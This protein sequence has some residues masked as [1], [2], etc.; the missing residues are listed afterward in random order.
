MF[1]HLCNH[2]IVSTQAGSRLVMQVSTA[3]G[4]SG[5]LKV[6]RF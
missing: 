1:I 3:A 4:T 6:S 2:W 5:L